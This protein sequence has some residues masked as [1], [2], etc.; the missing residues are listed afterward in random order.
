MILRQTALFNLRNFDVHPQGD[1]RV[2]PERHTT[3][4]RHRLR[5]GKSDFGSNNLLEEVDTSTTSAEDI[6]LLEAAST[7]Q[8]NYFVPMH[9]LPHPELVRWAYESLVE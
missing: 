7:L 8:Q 5:S 3:R 9:V 2:L 1:P 6:K 4:E